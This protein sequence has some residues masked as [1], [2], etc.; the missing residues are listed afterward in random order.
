MGATLPVIVFLYE[1]MF[2]PPDFR[3]V[4][5]LIRWCFREGRMALLGALCVLIYIPA[6]LGAGGLAQD[7]RTTFPAYTWAR[8]LEDTGT[9]LGYLLYRNNPAA[10]LNVTP[11][12]PL[13]V[14]VFFAILIAVA[15][16]LRSRVAWFGLLFF[17]ITLLPV[18]FIPARLGFV[19]YLPL[20]GLALYAAVCLVRFKE[21]LCRLITRTRCPASS[22]F[23]SHAASIRGRAVPGDG[24]S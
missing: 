12:T 9:Y 5:A 18:S 19:L 6:K 14:A 4:R 24:C 2:H 22:S 21:S 8:W 13:G 7:A 11:L 1:L 10:P 23:R 20:A 3:S 16:W 15:L 17:A